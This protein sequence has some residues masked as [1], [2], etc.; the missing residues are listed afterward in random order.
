MHSNKR[1]RIDE[2]SAGDIVAAMG[3][4]I[5][6]TGDTLCTENDPILLEPIQINE[7][8]ISVAV[9]PKKV[10][11]HD[12]LLEALKKLSDE[13]PTFKTKIDEET[14]QTLISG[15]GELHLEILTGRLKRE[16]PL[17]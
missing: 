13:D 14:G 5:T 16:F 8:V 12:K 9:E 3:L 6:T 10:Q 17:K 11:D 1:E 7:P 4:K 2:V 15:M